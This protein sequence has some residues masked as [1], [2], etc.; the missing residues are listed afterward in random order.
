MEKWY[1][2]EAFQVQGWNP[3]DPW[4]GIEALSRVTSVVRSVYS[5]QLPT[6]R[7]EVPCRVCQTVFNCALLLQSSL[8][9][10][11]FVHP[12][13]SV[14]E[15]KIKTKHVLYYPDIWSMREATYFIWGLRHSTHESVWYVIKKQTMSLLR[16]L[17][18]ISV[19]FS[20]RAGIFVGLFRQVLPFSRY[21]SL[22]QHFLIHISF[23]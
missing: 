9:M 5:F 23:T 17:N 21:N 13:H 4:S 2:Y 22:F 11:V 16:G 6:H 15:K 3:S 19:S 10:L 1:L 8:S 14:G 18:E 7:P 12:L 20:N